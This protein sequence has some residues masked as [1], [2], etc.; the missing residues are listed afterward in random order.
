[1][2]EGGTWVNPRLAK[3]KRVFIPAAPPLWLA[4]VEVVM[5]DSHPSPCP[6]PHLRRQTLIGAGMIRGAVYGQFSLHLKWD[7][8]SCFG[9]RTVCF[10]ARLEAPQAHAA[11]AGSQVDPEHGPS[12][13][14]THRFLDHPVF[15]FVFFKKKT[16]SFYIPTHCNFVIH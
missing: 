10:S 9:V 7:R 6:L 5:R 16:P 11:V 14:K 12:V 1:M 8:T 15:L 4:R 13:C 3:F 2:L